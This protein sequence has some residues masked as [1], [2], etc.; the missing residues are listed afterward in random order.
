MVEAKAI[1]FSKKKVLR[2]NQSFKKIIS[3]LIEKYPRLPDKESLSFMNNNFIDLTINTHQ[4]RV[5]NQFFLALEENARDIPRSGEIKPRNDER[6]KNNAVA[7]GWN[8][9]ASWTQFLRHGIRR[10]GLEIWL[11]IGKP[12][13]RKREEER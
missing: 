10:G 7:N 1:I 11:I 4:R 2:Q 9:K 8:S 3:L 6:N 12:G 13:Q 5:W